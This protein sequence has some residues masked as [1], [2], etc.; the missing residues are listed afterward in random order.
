MSAVDLILI[1][2]NEGDRLRRC[3]ASAQ[4]QARRMVYVD[5]GSSDGSVAAAEAAG[6]EVVHLDLSRPFTAARARHQGFLHLEATGGAAEIVQFIDGDCA[7]APG[8]IETARAALL[9]EPKRGLVTGWRREIAPGASIYNA[10]AQVEWHRP[11]GEIR[12]C[13]GDMMLRRTAYL[14]AGGFD[15][16]VIAAED[17]ELC[18][19]LRKAGWQLLRIAEEMTQHDA[20]MTRFGA[21]WQRAVRT[22]HGFAQVGHLHPDYFRR[23]RMRS[24]LW[25]LLAPVLALVGLFAAPWLTALVLLA[26]VLSWLRTA[27]GLMRQEG[28]PRAT[29]LHHAVFLTLSKFP[30]LIGMLRFHLRRWMGRDMRIIEYK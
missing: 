4:G 21:W 26:Y 8:W 12:A 13:G 10:L 7:I 6:A 25:G 30:N 3:L 18:C 24:W 29:A 17:D 1:G 15:A 20:A 23:E 2:R 11:A 19:R 16:R 27:R 14:E 22:G 9:A 5:S 28:L